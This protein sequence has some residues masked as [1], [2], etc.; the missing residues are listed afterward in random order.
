MIDKDKFAAFLR[1]TNKSVNT[2]TSYLYA[3]EQFKK[4]QGDCRA[5][6]E[7]GNQ[8]QAE[9]CSRLSAF[10]SPPLRQELPGTVQ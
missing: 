10:I 4:L 1:K 8:I 7:A 9:S 3:L 6:E 5:V 2:I